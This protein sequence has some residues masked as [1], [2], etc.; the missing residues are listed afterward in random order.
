MVF[1][2]TVSFTYK[3]FTTEEAKT[4]ID[5]IEKSISDLRATMNLNSKRQYEIQRIIKIINHLNKK[6]KSLQNNYAINALAN[7]VGWI[8]INYKKGMKHGLVK[9]FD[10]NGEV[11]LEAIY[12][13]DQLVTK[14]VDK[15]QK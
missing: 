8:E 15:V 12:K 9:Y 6:D 14:K 5:N 3:Y 1:V 13:D 7:A 11:V 4:K 10:R 2:T